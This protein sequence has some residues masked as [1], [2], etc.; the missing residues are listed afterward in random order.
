[1][2]SSPQ[3]YN[4]AAEPNHVTPALQAEMVTEAVSDAKS[5][6]WVG[7]LF[8]Y[9]ALDAGTSVL[10]NQNFFGLSTYNGTHKPA[11]TALQTALLNG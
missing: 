8:F 4:L 1:V 5:Y 2:A 11:W 10:S 7:A 6:G 9:S 3:N